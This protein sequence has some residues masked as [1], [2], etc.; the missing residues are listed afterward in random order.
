MQD[1]DDLHQQMLV[2]IFKKQFIL[3]QSN[4]KIDHR[5]NQIGIEEYISLSDIKSMLNLL[6]HDKK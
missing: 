4:W 6:N 5:D 2:L 3:S 1:S